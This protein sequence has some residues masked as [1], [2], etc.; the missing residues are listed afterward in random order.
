ME[1]VPLDLL[2]VTI[3]DQTS[4]YNDENP[5]VA[6]DYKSFLMLI[7]Q[8]HHRTSCFPVNPAPLG[9]L[10]KKNEGSTWTRPSPERWTCNMDN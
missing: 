2:P 3:M 8:A 6:V 1:I 10:L 5:N 7:T 9:E 4:N